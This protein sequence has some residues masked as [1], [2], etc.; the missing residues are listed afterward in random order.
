ME[1]QH[2]RLVSLS[3]YHSNLLG[4]LCLGI[5]RQVLG[6]EPMGPVLPA[7]TIHLY[8]R[9]SAVGQ[10][11]IFGSLANT[12]IT[13]PTKFVSIVV[14]SVLLSGNPLSPKQ[15]IFVLMVFIPNPSQ[16]EEAA[17]VAQE[18]YL[19]FCSFFNHPTVY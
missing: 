11:F 5:Q 14:V 10:N 4:F 19:P 12:T 18:K 2:S 1:C 7:A 9:C 3:L 8:C 17:E 16:V 13:T 6:N 15:W